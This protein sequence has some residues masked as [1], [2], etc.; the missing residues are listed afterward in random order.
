M[1]PMQ[2]RLKNLPPNDAQAATNSSD[3]YRAIRNTPLQRRR[4]RSPQAV[5]LDKKWHP[6]GKGPRRA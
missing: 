5:G 4:S 6:P 2:L 1:D 3:R